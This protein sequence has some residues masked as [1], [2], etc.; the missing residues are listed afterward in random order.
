MHFSVVNMEMMQMCM[1][2]PRVST[3]VTIKAGQYSKDNSQDEMLAHDIMTM[4]VDYWENGELSR[5]L[6]KKGM[7]THQR[8][9]EK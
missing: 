9:V 6:Q 7:R 8:R 4:F 1:V 3:A 2:V 5:E